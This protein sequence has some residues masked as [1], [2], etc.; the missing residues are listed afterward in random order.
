MIAKFLLGCW[1]N[2]AVIASL[3]LGSRRWS[4]CG[5]KV[6]SLVWEMLGLGGPCNN[7]EEGSRRLGVGAMEAAWIKDR[8]LGTVS[9]GSRRGNQG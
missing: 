2:G 7:W 8:D 6:M 3:I 1:V 9:L 4:R 5:A